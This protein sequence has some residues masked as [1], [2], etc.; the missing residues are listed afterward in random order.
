MTARGIKKE[1]A[2]T[3]TTTFRGRFET[4]PLLQNQLFMMLHRQG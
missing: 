4:D 2:A 3:V 1:S